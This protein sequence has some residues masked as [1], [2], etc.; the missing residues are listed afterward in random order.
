MLEGILTMYFFCSNKIT[1]VFRGKNIIII[2]INYIK[3]MHSQET[4]THT[5]IYNFKIYLHRHHIITML[6]QSSRLLRRFLQTLLL[7]RRKL[8]RV[9]LSLSRRPWFFKSCNRYMYFF[10]LVLHF[11]HII[12]QIRL[13]SSFFSLYF[14]NSS[15]LFLYL[16]KC[17]FSF[18]LRTTF[19][20]FSSNSTLSNWVLTYFSSISNCC[21]LESVSSRVYK[22]TTT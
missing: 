3:K 20:E 12:L 16:S 17:T 22:S 8:G 2:H 11:L 9:S 19:V 6:F 4:H 7:R 1:V 15:T 5:Y 10:F 13:Q 21:A 14:F 18:C